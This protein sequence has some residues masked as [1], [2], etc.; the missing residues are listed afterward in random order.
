M[1]LEHKLLLSPTDIEVGDYIK[2]PRVPEQANPPTEDTDYWV[3]VSR[4]KIDAE[5]YRI[6]IE[7]E[8]G[9]EESNLY[10][11]DSLIEVFYTTIRTVYNLQE[12]DSGEYV[13]QIDYKRSEFYNQ[14]FKL[15]EVKSR[16]QIDGYPE[17]VV[18]D[19]FLIR[20][21]PRG[22]A[23]R[24]AEIY[25]VEFGDYKPWKIEQIWSIDKIRQ[26]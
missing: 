10:H 22:R 20:Y 14:F 7:N 23:F 8:E 16:V 3:E 5:N 1:R 6:Y 18:S 21:E 24:E 9:D 25:R 26:T 2:N 13:Y 11:Q 19:L 4:I 17:L 12:N 15:K